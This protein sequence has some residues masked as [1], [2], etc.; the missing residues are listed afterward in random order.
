MMRGMMA[1]AAA[2][3]LG[4]T[5][6]DDGGG[7]SGG[8]GDDTE[9]VTINSVGSTTTFDRAGVNLAI[10]GSGNAITIAATAE[11][12]AL[13]LGGTSNMV[14]VMDGATI[15]SCA[16]TGTDGTL[17]VPASYSLSCSDSG[18]GNSVVTR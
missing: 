4:L 7:D 2:A 13:D 8:G 12:E 11:I 3:A 16:M 17:E 1:V 10:D 9:T 5:G 6:C 14:T 15:E 18:T